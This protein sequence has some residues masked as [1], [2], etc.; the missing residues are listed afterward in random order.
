M[1]PRRW[2]WLSAVFAI[3]RQWLS[4]R[5]GR[6]PQTGGSGVIGAPFCPAPAT[7]GAAVC[8]ESRAGTR[9]GPGSGQVTPACG[10]SVPT[11]C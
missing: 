10:C 7:R 8:R 1:N 6:M 2:V 3:E 11:D 4:C 9:V 5:A